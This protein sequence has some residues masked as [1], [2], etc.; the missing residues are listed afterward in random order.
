M[1]ETLRS[2][3]GHTLLS[4]NGAADIGDD[5]DLLGSGLVDSVGMISL[6]LFIEEEFQL[7]VPPEHVTIENFLSINAIDAYVRRRQQNP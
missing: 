7:A 6:V 4:L 3:I 2:Y 5:D 1:K